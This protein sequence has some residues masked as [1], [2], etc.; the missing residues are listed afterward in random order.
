MS[1]CIREE[2]GI[3]LAKKQ[4]FYLFDIE[5]LVSNH[6]S[7]NWKKLKVPE[8]VLWNE[9]EIVI[10]EA[11]SSIPRDVHKN[12]EPHIERTISECGYK[13]ISKLDCYCAELREKYTTALII[14][15][16]DIL[17]DF[18]D[19]IRVDDVQ[20]IDSPD[21]LR[22][23]RISKVKIV[24][25]LWLLKNLPDEMV[26]VCKDTF[27]SKI[28]PKLKGWQKNCEIVVMNEKMAVEQGYAIRQ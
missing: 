22:K 25:L 13:L 21:L 19:D 16:P 17:G 20:L 3:L 10:V 5:K 7:S 4:G 26:P 11:K 2:S 1:V 15:R 28:L 9:K 6:P 24:R 8:F 23:C 27:N 18:L 14:L 12:L